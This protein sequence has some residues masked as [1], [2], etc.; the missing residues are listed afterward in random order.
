M[1]FNLLPDCLVHMIMEYVYV[2]NSNGRRWY[3]ETLPIICKA[4]Y[5][6][7]KT[8][9]KQ[10]KVKCIMINKRCLVHKNEDFYRSN[11]ETFKI[12]EYYLS[13]MYDKEKCREDHEDYEYIHFKSVE[14]TNTF[15]KNYSDFFCMGHKCCSGRGV[16]ISKKS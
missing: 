14:Q 13:D 6:I 12:L 8:I 7:M 16:R 5:K 4:M 1:I 10:K 3:I 15:I 9:V 2:D 11:L